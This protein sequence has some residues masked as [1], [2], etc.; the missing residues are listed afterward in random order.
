MKTSILAR[1]SFVCAVFLSLSPFSQA[2]AQISFLDLQKIESAF[3][4]EYDAE[5]SSANASFFINKPPTPDMPTFWWNR[6]EA[7]A[8]YGSYIDKETGYREHYIF[9]FSGFASLPGMTVDAAVLT[10]CHELGHGLAGAPYKDKFPGEADISV[11]ALADEFAVK[12]CFPRMAKRIQAPSIISNH[13]ALVRTQE[14]ETFIRNECARH[15]SDLSRQFYCLRVFNALEFERLYYRTSP[16]ILED[17]AFERK[18]PS[19]VSAVITKADYYPHSQCRIDTMLAGLFN[20]PR[21]A[22][23]WPAGASRLYS[24]FRIRFGF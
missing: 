12:S 16:D 19:R 13:P 10:I 22:C 15:F 21:P 24:P 5:L 6:T 1:L 2:H 17:T 3:H 14:G 11:E 9:F 8:S 7:R 4:A 18:D 23:W 20:E